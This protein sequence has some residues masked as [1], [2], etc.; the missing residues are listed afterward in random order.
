MS[1]KRL[2]IATDGS[3]AAHTAVEAGLELAASSQA[4][5]TFVHITR[6]LSDRLYRNDPRHPPTGKELQA[7]DTVLRHA[8][9]RAAARGVPASVE[10]IAA[11]D[12]SGIAD[13]ILG[14]A[15]AKR[16]DIIVVGSRGRGLVAG[17]F[18][19]SVSQ[20]VLKHA[21]TPVLVTPPG[22]QLSKS[23]QAAHRI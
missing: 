5:V 13:A 14:V 15:D 2:V 16:A 4:E 3:P 10:V 17:T 18:L 11:I 19:G 12:P 9:N 21:R 23:D 22:V 6:R 1:I 20:H 7:A 8:T